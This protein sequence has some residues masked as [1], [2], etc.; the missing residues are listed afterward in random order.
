M[1][2]TGIAY[3]IYGNATGIYPYSREPNPSIND[4]LDLL[5]KSFDSMVMSLKE[6]TKRLKA[7]ES[8]YR[9]LYEGLPDLCRTIDTKGI[10][11][12][13]NKAY[14]EHLG[15]SKEELVGA[16][17]FEHAAE[18]SL[19]AIHESFETWKKTGHVS[20]KEVW[21]KRKDG[22]IFPA[23]ISASNLFDE[24]GNLIGSNTII[25]D[26]SE[27]QKLQEIDRAKAEFS[28]MIT[29]ELKTPLVPIQGYCELLLDGTLGCL[30]NEQKEKIQVMYD[31]A[32]SLLQLI[33]DVL[34]VHKLE[35]DKIKFE[36]RDV[37][38]KEIIDRSIKRLVPI[39][40]VK[41]TE[42]LDGTDP[43]IILR[44]DPE[45]ILQVINNLV[46]NAL[47]FVPT[48][49][50]RIE[51]HATRDA[52]SVVFTV[53]DNG[54]GIPKEK[55]QNLFKK[56]YQVDASLRRHAGGSGLGLAICRGIVEA[57][58]G[59]IWVKSEEGKGT[60][61]HFSVPVGGKHR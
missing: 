37:T 27:I 34:D 33:Q 1:I 57:H 28:S 22:T 60:T 26:M 56:F 36:M 54:I 30:S 11:L 17:I 12:D 3:H 16:S 10:I 7:A 21:L 53:K 18:Q 20:N 44:C 13:C 45:R 35:L 42:L 8:R 41:D 6:S 49:G 2:M 23:L 51:I 14:A 55:Q 39:A 25:K 48:H 40:K 24:D 61:F 32:L 4:E 52:S 46:G 43:Q 19:D 38:A 59:K 9:N 15:Y 47:K 31:S 58:K 50:G 5:A 29:H